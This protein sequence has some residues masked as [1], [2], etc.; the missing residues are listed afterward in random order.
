[1]AQT[2]ARARPRSERWRD[3]RLP[4][5][6]PPHWGALYQLVCLLARSAGVVK[7]RSADRMITVGGVH[8]LKQ[9]FCDT[10]IMIIVIS[11]ISVL[12]RPWKSGS[13]MD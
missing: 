9:M 5:G 7:Q 3:R 4:Y 6:I 13:Y 1:M 10:V 8:V 11:W 12:L 2:C